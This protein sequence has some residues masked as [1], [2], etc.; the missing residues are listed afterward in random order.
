[1]IRRSRSPSTRA[2]K[3][4]GRIGLGRANADRDGLRVV[5]NPHSRER[6]LAGRPIRISGREPEPEG[7]EGRLRRWLG[8]AN[9]NGPE[10]GTTLD[11]GPA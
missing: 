8:E 9:R 1:M 10:V 7:G 3:P 6:L 2:R 11:T 5:S 4:A